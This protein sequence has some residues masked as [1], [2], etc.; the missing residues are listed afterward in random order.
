MTSQD[1]YEFCAEDRFWFR[2]AYT[3]GRCPLCGEGAPGGAPEL[4]LML[5]ADR[6]SL[7]MFGVALVSVAMSAFVLVMYFHAS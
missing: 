3:D 5:R 4:P 1:E 7:G 6:F 2:P